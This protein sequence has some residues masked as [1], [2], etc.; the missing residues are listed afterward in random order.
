MESPPACTTRARTRTSDFRFQIADFTRRELSSSYNLQSLL[1]MALFLRFLF[2]ATDS[3]L[4][5]VFARGFLLGGLLGSF[6]PFPFLISAV[7]RILVGRLFLHVSIMSQIPTI[8]RY[9]LRMAL[10]CSI[11]EAGRSVSLRP[12]PMELAFSNMRNFYRPIL[13][14]PTSMHL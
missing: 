11:W 14:N 9:P 2:D 7:M 8:P 1:R 3:G 6:S 12:F 4:T 5:D 13:F 10:V